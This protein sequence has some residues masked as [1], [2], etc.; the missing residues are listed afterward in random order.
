MM[1]PTSFNRSKS[2]YKGLLSMDSEIKV[3]ISNVLSLFLKVFSIFVIKAE[4]VI[5]YENSAEGLV[6][7]IGELKKST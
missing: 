7:L 6:T 3:L 2:R 1:L 4:E 5:L